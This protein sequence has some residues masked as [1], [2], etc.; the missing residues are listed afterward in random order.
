MSADSEH[1]TADMKAARALAVVLACMAGAAVAVEAVFPTDLN[2]RDFGAK[3]DGVA[4]DTAA[5]QA[6]ADA[7][8][9]RAN[10]L[11]KGI[12]WRNLSR[13]AQPFFAMPRLVFP[14]GTYRVSGPVFFERNHFLLGLDGA[15]V[16]AA[17]DDLDVF[18]FSR[19]ARQFVSGL[20]MEGGSRQFLVETLNNEAAI[21]TARDCTFRRAK[22]TAVDSHSWQ[23]P[24]SDE[25][26]KL[27]R[28][29]TYR[30]NAENG[31][32]ERDPR[33]D[34]PELTKYNNSSLIT[35]ERCRFED[36]QVATDINP[37]G[38]V[39]R[40]LEIK[41][42]V[43]T[44]CVFR[45]ANNLHAYDLD[46]T[47]RRPAGAD[48]LAFVEYLGAHGL[49]LEHSRFRSSGDG[50]VTLVR[51]ATKKAGYISNTLILRALEV[52]CGG[53]P[54]GGIVTCP[55]GSLVELVS[56][57]DV[58]DTTGR[59]V[60]AIAYPDGVSSEDYD[61]FRYFRQFSGDY[62]YSIML[63]RNSPNV[64]ESLPPAAERYRE[65]AEV[66]PS[67]VPPL[68]VPRPAAGGEVLW[69]P[70]YGVGVRSSTNDTAA[71][72]RLFA[73]AATKP[74]AKVV[75][76]P[77][78]IELA[79]TVELSGDFSVTAAGVAR[80]ET[81]DDGLTLFKVADGASARF[82]HI[83]F[84]GGAHHVAC[85]AMTG[86]TV[87]VDSCLSFDAAKAAFQ[88][89]TRGNPDD[90]RFLLNGGVHYHPL[91][92]AGNARAT[93]S[94]AWFRSLPPDPTT[95]FTESVALVNYGKMRY[96][97]ILGVPCVFARFPKGA[98]TASS[99]D[100]RWIDNRGGELHALF[101]RFGG[102]WGGIP[103]VYDYKGGKVLI[104]GSN[105]YFY[106][107]YT[108]HQPIV[109]DGVPADLQIFGVSCGFEVLAWHGGL[110][111]LRRTPKGALEPIPNAK[112]RGNVPRVA[113]DKRNGG[114]EKKL[115]LIGL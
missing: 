113:G 82:S 50:G 103:P 108:A 9:A 40:E 66:V 87:A 20:T 88:M 14:A 43:S 47:V 69:G 13:A 97:D 99:G 27:V 39:F 75:L 48:S 92:Y 79:E 68:E 70:D 94:G 115:H 23:L 102:E 31:K 36:C 112:V 93:L 78:S 100:Y 44:G 67:P 15:T 41:T 84:E 61:A 62:T 60:K 59:R 83:F 86:A 64:D 46:V 22:T 81:K 95:N 25:R 58:T 34:S 51:V 101:T 107:R 71:M 104:E 45:V 90:L 7:A 98:V 96:Q 4:D 55:K 73:T 24:K 32:W 65:S 42:S 26:P 57:T 3:G 29:G 105:A 37:D 114:G 110:A 52:A 16:K 77:R 56:I 38:A 74:G 28:V 76:P 80:I 106:P 54:E 21:F 35:V 11:A 89:A 91:W 49:M 30:K 18:V 2:V 10:K 53:C 5:L 72:K 63:G 6:A 111:F 109:T 8:A 17:S 85:L 1:D 33:R 19:T 12:G